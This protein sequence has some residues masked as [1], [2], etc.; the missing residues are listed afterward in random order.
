MQPELAAIETAAVAIDPRDENILI[1]GRTLRP[2]R[3]GSLIVN[4]PYPT[5]REQQAS[6]YNRHE[7]PL[8][9][10]KSAAAAA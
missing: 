9:A 5:G 4:Q 3:I 8:R 7:H 2:D 10:G 1:A 6:H